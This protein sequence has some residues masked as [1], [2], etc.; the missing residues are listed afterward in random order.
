MKA[1]HAPSQSTAV[2]SGHLGPVPASDLTVPVEEA[3][4]RALGSWE[5][6]LALWSPSASWFTSFLFSRVADQGVEPELEPA[7]HPDGGTEEQGEQVC[8]PRFAPWPCCSACPAHC[9]LLALQ[10]P[11]SKGPARG[12][13]H[14]RV[15]SSC[16][17]S[18]ELSPKPEDRTSDPAGRPTDA[19]QNSWTSGSHV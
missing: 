16:K 18:Q 17:P 7:D 4:H 5:A 1:L 6:P 9:L 8:S 11:S 10:T 12:G 14:G 15:Q 3:G 19:R 13:D 2:W